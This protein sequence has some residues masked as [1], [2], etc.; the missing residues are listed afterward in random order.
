MNLYT[1]RFAAYAKSHKMSPDEILKHDRKMYP[2]GVMCGY[3]LWISK[4]LKEYK[5]L[6]PSAYLGNV[7]CDQ[8]GFTKFLET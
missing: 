6:N 7:L 3:I 8:E 4:K 2:G 5:K 1:L